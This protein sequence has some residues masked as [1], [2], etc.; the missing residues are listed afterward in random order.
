MNVVPHPQRTLPRTSMF[1]LASMTAETVSG[2]VKIR[3]LSP[4]GALI[5]GAALPRLDEHL[6]IR[7]GELAAT[8][9]VI[10]CDGGKA[11]LRFD[12]YVDV[13]AWLPAG[14][15]QQQVDQAFHAIKHGPTNVVR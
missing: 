9:R 3:N 6:A 15:P 8:G 7:R 14:P 10:W 5:E 12:H 11:G 13:A 1:V 2:P 4:D